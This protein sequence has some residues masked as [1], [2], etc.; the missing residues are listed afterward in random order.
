MDSV[1]YLPDDLLVKLDRATMAS[2]IEGRAPMLDARLV[3]FAW[4]LPITAK[5]GNGRG[6]LILRQVLD[7]YVP[8]ILVDRPKMG[9]SVPLGLWLR[10]PL[11]E[12]AEE[13][14]NPQ[15]L[16]SQNFFNVAEVNRIWVEHS[17]NKRDWSSQLWSILMFQAWLIEEKNGDVR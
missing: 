15:L 14:L 7:R 2:S 3:E 8:K 5:I 9:F 17:S 10:G 12:W 1:T 13:L 16:T 4:K 11:K 6:K